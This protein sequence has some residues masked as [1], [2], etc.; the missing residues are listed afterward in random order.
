M[1]VILKNAV[2]YVG[3]PLT[4]AVKMVSSTPAMVIGID[5][6]KG[7]IKENYDADLVLFDEDINIKKVMVNGKFIK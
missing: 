2:K 7:F 4:D 5:N 3:I 1:D 6:K